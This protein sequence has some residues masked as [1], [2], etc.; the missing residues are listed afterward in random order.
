MTAPRAGHM[1]APMGAAALFRKRKPR[2]TARTS[3][4][5]ALLLFDRAVRLEP[6]QPAHTVSGSIDPFALSQLS[7]LTQPPVRSIRL[8]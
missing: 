4:G 5:L 7:R 8:P 3:R 6:T 1:L 2:P